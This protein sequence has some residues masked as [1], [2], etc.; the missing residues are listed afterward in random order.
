MKKLVTFLEI[1]V[2]IAVLGLGVYGAFDEGSPVRGRSIAVLIMA[3]ILP[4]FLL[5]SF[6]YTASGIRKT[7]KVGWGKAYSLAWKKFVGE[8]KLLKARMKA[9]LSW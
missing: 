3:V 1:L 8:M 4:F 7:K 6:S 5:A 2:I 9:L